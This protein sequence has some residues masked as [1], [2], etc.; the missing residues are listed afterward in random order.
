MPNDSDFEND[1]D[2]IVITPE[3][4]TWN[5]YCESFATNEAAFTDEKSRLL[6]SKYMH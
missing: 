1:T 2:P 4:R 3:G 5:P 6:A